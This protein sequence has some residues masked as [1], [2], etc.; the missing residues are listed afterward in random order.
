[1]F[2]SSVHSQEKD[3]LKPQKDSLSPLQE[4]KVQARTGEEEISRQTP[5]KLGRKLKNARIQKGLEIADIQQQ[6]K[7]SRRNLMAMETGFYDEMPAFSFCRGFYKMYANA[8]GLDP[9]DIV[10][11]FEQEYNKHKKDDDMP[12]FDFDNHSKDVD[13]IAGRPSLLAFSSFG[14]ILLL[15]LFFAG[16][17]CWF[18]SWNPASFLSQQL[19]TL[20][21]DRHYEMPL[22][23]I[24]TGS[25]EKHSQPTAPEQKKPLS[26]C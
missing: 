24:T 18:F 13:S 16:F 1:M 10:F 2:D 7:I 15:L 23:G 19:Q 21:P 11:Q 3:T 14:F 9:N 4:T 20:S 17:L 26:L 5:E 22:S 25:G 6:T 8:V 12:A